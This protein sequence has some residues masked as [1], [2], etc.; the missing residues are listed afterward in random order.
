MDEKTITVKIEGMTCNHCVHAVQSA[1]EEIDGISKAV[2]S[3]EKKSA[4]VSCDP[5][6]ITT[7]QIVDIIEEEGYSPSIC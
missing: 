1:L 7:D 2:V 4:V 6:R 3:L 5:D